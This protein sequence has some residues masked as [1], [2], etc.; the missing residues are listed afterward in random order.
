MLQTGLSRDKKDLQDQLWTLRKN[1]TRSS[2]KNSSLREALKLCRKCLQERDRQL[3]IANRM[4]QKLSLHQEGLEV[5][6]NLLVWR[7]LSFCSPKQAVSS[8]ISQLALCIP[9]QVTLVQNG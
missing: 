5:T 1:Y 3:D 9:G 6:P 2:E 4:I 8:V 7:V